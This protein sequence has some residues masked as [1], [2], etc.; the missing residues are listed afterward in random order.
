[1]TALCFYMRFK[2]FFSSIS[3]TYHFWICFFFI[4]VVWI[5]IEIG[6]NNT[7]FFF[8]QFWSCFFMDFFKEF[9]KCFPPIFLQFSSGFL[10]VLRGFFG[11]TQASSWWRWWFFM[12]SCFWILFYNSLKALI[13]SK[14]FHLYILS[15]LLVFQS[16]HV[17]L[18]TFLEKQVKRREKPLNLWVDTH[19]WGLLNSSSSV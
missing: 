11:D 9:S 10:P 2:S 3:Q 18:F 5:S 16:F 12:A 15:V 1:M 8:A 14:T 7:F 6:K 19:V 13:E 17:C 4:Y